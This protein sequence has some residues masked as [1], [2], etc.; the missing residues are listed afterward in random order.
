MLMFESN[1]PFLA[2]CT[3]KF[4]LRIPRFPFK[5]LRELGS[6]WRH[7]DT[8]CGQRPRLGRSFGQHHKVVRSRAAPARLVGGG[9][10]FFGLE[11]VLW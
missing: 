3:D 9:S 8:L 1:P 5:L 2:V 4:I 7:Q 6:S 11:G 10:G